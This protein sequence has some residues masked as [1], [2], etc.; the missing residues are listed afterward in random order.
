MEKGNLAKHRNNKP[1]ELDGVKLHQRAM[2]SILYLANGTRFNIAFAC[3]HFAQFMAYL[4]C[5]HWLRVKWIVQYLQGLKHPVLKYGG[6]KA[7]LRL[8]VCTGLDWR[9]CQVTRCLVDG[10]AFT[11]GGA[12]VTSSSKKKT[13]ILLLLIEAEYAASTIA[14]KEAL[15]LRKVLKTYRIE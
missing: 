15:W 6:K 9:G 4:C 12:V 3:Q 2:G 13:T 8:V 11:M 10:F 14:A 5:S 1:L 7:N